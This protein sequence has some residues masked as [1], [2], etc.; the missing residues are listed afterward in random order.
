MFVHVTQFIIFWDTS[1]T[2][3]C[4]TGSSKAGIDGIGRR[5]VGGGVGENSEKAFGARPV[6]IL[7][8]IEDGAGVSSER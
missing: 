3:C 6:C 1:A 4:N 8:G 7:R 2:A 5:R